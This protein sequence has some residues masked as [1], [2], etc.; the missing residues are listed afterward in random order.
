[1]KKERK[2]IGWASN[3]SREIWGKIDCRGERARSCTV[4]KIEADEIRES[5]IELPGRRP[6][7]TR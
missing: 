7:A 3:S 1:M 2:I 4:E 5:R 6:T